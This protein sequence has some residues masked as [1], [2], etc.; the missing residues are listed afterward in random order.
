[1]VVENA[2]EEVPERLIEGPLA[3]EEKAFGRRP[4]RLAFGGYQ[5]RRL[6]P[7]RGLAREPAE[8][9]SPLARTHERSF[10]PPGFTPPGW[11]P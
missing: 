4:G 6:I 9:I 10:A 8:R 2:I 7:R 11:S 3:P 1:M 5:S